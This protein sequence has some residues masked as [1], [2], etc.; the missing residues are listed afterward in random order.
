MKTKRVEIPIYGGYLNIQIVKNWK[1]INEEL[2]F[3]CTP[4]T[5]ATVYYTKKDGEY[6]E[7]F[8]SFLN[9]PYNSLICHESVHLTN[10][11]FN[12]KGLKLDSHNDE[13]QAYFTE[14]CFIQIE[15]FLEELKIQN[16][17]KLNN[18]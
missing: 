4:N 10:V 18:L 9:K 5:E 7:F 3:H 1:K 6:V 16:S 15:T 13:A 14:W 11:I 2:G 12:Y 17:K 8:V